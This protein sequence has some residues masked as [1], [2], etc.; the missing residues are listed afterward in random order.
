MRRLI[1]LVTALSI[2]S[3]CAT[4]RSFEFEGLV[5]YYLPDG[6][7]EIYDATYTET[8]FNGFKQSDKLSVDIGNDNVFFFSGIPYTFKGHLSSIKTGKSS[9][10]LNNNNDL[11]VFDDKGNCIILIDDEKY[12]IPADVY[13]KL[14]YQSNGDPEKLKKSLLEYLQNK[15]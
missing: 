9:V 8:Y 12:V 5:K 6:E 2:F 13:N 7:I 4:Y 3:S 15:E 14:K 1:L 11:V 10:V